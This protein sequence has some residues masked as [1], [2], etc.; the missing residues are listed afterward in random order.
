MRNETRAALAA[1]TAG[2]AKANGVTSVENS[3]TV[4]P[5]VAQTIERKIQESS[6]FLSAIN[7]MMVPEQTGQALKIA[8][9]SP[10]SSRTNTTTTARQPSVP[11]S[12]EDYSYACVHTDMDTAIS[13]AQLDAWAKF[14]NFA[15]LV[16]ASIIQ[17]QAL[18]R[19][20]IGWNGT[21]AAVS[22]NRAT[23]PLLQDVNIGWVKKV[24]DNKA[25]QIVSDASSSGGP[26][27]KISPTG[28]AGS[29]Y[30]NLDAL[31]FDLVNNLI[32]PWFRENPDLRVILGRDLAAD[33]YFPLV[34]AVQP[35]TE[36]N[37]AQ[38]ILSGKRIGGLPAVQLP[39]F[40]ANAVAVT[41]MKNL[42]IYTQEGT[43]RRYL[44][45][46]PEWSRIANYESVNDAYVVEEYD[47]FAY[48]ENI[49]FVA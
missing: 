26:A 49:T 25:S 27:I 30:A 46:E 36:K 31:V 33:V 12:L 41:T 34:N 14:P 22:T 35:P 3:F 20:M 5:S 10:V 16:R 4:T 43:R 9:G 47:L 11:Q 23:N 45:E 17:Q 8:V 32:A 7:M 29:D 18:D 42:S 13:Y 48:A 2:I 19:I 24:R 44:K 39:F 37:A 38:L 40:P 15:D 21:S 28:A 6:A 1:Y